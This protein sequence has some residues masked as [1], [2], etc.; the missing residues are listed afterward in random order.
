LAFVAGVAL[1]LG[2]WRQAVRGAARHEAL[3]GVLVAGALLHG[4]ALGLRPFLSMDVL[5]YAA[6][7][8]VLERGGDPHA[9]LAAT[10]PPGDALLALLLPAWRLGSSAYADGFHALLRLLV[11]LT[12]GAL[13]LLLFAL[14][15]TAAVAVLLSSLCLAQAARLLGRS[16]AAAA[17][18]LLFCPLVLLEA[19]VNAHNDA[20]LLLSLSAALWALAARQ[21]L[22]ALALLAAG[23]SIKASAALALALVAWE[24]VLLALRDRGWAPPLR[25]L[26]IA[27]PLVALAGLGAL[28]RLRHH[29]L[30]HALSS[31]LGWS[32]EAVPHCTRSV[33]CLPRG[34]LFYLAHAPEL[35]HLVGLPF[36]LLAGCWLLLV[37]ARCLSTAPLEGRERT[38]ALVAALASSLLGYYLWLHAFMQS[39]YLLVLVPLLP[40][41]DDRE[42]P[43]LVTFL[44]TSTL[45]YAIALPLQ[46]ARDPLG[47]GGREFFCA[48]LT[49]LPATFVWLRAI[50][51]RGR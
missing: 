37:P 40:F 39:W 23:L 22:L 26:S 43:A 31:L 29:P 47:A 27:A 4:A 34:A 44:V 20:L 32:G 24:L 41:V 36:R 50:R 2:A 17:A 8:R 49:V 45:Y 18:T 25:L 1:L 33:E 48:A 13:P 16:P 12:Q 14:Q 30:L 38:I 51:G 5:F 9:A 42:R 10:L 11:T 7:A 6:T 15:A 21:R 28:L 35:S 19:T 46:C 3:W